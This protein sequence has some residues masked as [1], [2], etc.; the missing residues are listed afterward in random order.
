MPVLVA[1]LAGFVPAF[2]ANSGALA[3]PLCMLPALGRSKR[4]PISGTI[5]FNGD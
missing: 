5:M 4:A 2:V 3:L 1:V